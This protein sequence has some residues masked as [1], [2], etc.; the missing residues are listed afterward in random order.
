M[1]KCVLIGLILGAL[2]FQHLFA[3]EVYFS[4][5]GQQVRVQSGD[6]KGVYDLWLRPKADTVKALPKFEIYDAGIGGFADVLAGKPSTTTTFEL[7]PFE[8]LYTVQGNSVREITGTD[9]VKGL[10]ISILAEQKYL[11]RWVEILQLTETAEQGWILRAKTDNGDDVNNFNVRFI[12]QTDKLFDLVSMDLVIGLYKTNP[13]TR[14]QLKPLF[15]KVAPQNL[16]VTGEE[17]TKVSVLDAF[18]DVITPENVFQV[19]RFGLENSWAL[20]LSGSSERLNNMVIQTENGITPWIISPIIKQSETLSAPTLISNAG[21]DCDQFQLRV[22]ANT[23]EYAPEKT[24]WLLENRRFTGIETQHKFTQK[25]SVKLQLITPTKGRYTPLY[26]VTEPTV[27]VNQKPNLVLKG[28]KSIISPSEVL[29]LNAQESS[30]PENSELS[31]A[32]FV[33]GV[34]RGDAPLLNFSA[35]TSGDY[36]VRL[37]LDDKT[38]GSACSTV[39]STFTIRINTQPYGEI[40]LNPIV[41]LGTQTRFTAASLLDSDGDSLAFSWEVNGIQGSNT[42]ES[43]LVNHAERGTFDVKLTVNDISGTTNASFETI[44]SFKVNGAPEPAFTL[45]NLIA[46]DQ[47]LNLNAAPSTDPDQDRLS[48]AWAISDGRTSQNPQFALAFE[49]PGDYEITLTVNDKQGVSNSIKSIKK[50]IRVNEEP[51]PVITSVD[52][53]N[54]ALVVFRADQS[55]DSDQSIAVYSWNF[56]DNSTAQGSQVN[57][58]YSRAGTYTVTLTVDD[59]QNMANSVQ[60]IQKEVIVNKNPIAQFSVKTLVAPN[61]R[62]VLDGSESKDEDGNVTQYLWFHQ[63]KQIGSG[64]QFTYSIAEPG[65][66]VIQLQVKDDSGFDSAIHKKTR[67]IRVNFPP[68]IEWTATPTVTEPGKKTIFSA[69]NSFDFDDKNLNFTWDFG[70]GKTYTGAQISHTFS[71]SGTFSFKITAD[72]NNGLT[73]SKTVYEE[74]IRVNASPIIVTEQRIVTNSKAVVLNAAKSYDADGSPLEFTWILPDGTKQSEPQLTWN[75]PAGGYYKIGLTLNDRDGLQ[76][77]TISTGIDVLVNRPVVALVDSLIESCTGQIIIFSSARSYD[78]DGDQFSTQWDFGDGNTSRDNNPYHTYEKPGVYTATLTLH[79]GISAEPT[80]AKIPVKVSGSPTAR[81]NFV[82][83][84]IC[85]NTPMIFDGSKS[86]DPNG[87]IGAYSWDFGDESVGFGTQVTH[88]FNRA[89]TYTVQLTVIGS[90]A[91]NCSN[92]SVTTATVRVVEGPEARFEVPEWTNPGEVITLDASKSVLNGT[93][94]GAQWIVTNP[95]S[96]ET[97]L[98]GLQQRF[99]PQSSGKLTIQLI[100]EVESGSDC[101]ISYAKKE[102]RVNFPPVLAWDKKPIYA[103]NKA[104]RVRATGSGDR[105]G[106]IQTYTWTLNGNKIEGGLEVQLGFLKPGNYTL[107]LTIS[108]NSG[109]TSGT[110]SKTE[111]FTVNAP[112][113]SQFNL[114]NVIYKGESIQLVPSEINDAEGQKLTTTWMVNGSKMDTTAFVATANAYQIKL[115]QNDE[116][117]LENAV[118]SVSKMVHIVQPPN[119]LYYAPRNV[120]Q[121]YTI[122]AATYHA[123][124]KV[125]LS[126]DGNQQKSWTAT[127]VGSFNL[128]WVWTP[129]DTVLAQTSFPVEVFEPLALVDDKPEAVIVKWN[130]AN[131]FA[132]LTLPALNRPNPDALDSEWFGTTGSLGYGTSLIVP[133]KK[134]E[135]QFT[136]VVKEFDVEG[137]KPLRFTVTVVAE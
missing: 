77:S 125:F 35:S 76:N 73:N 69:G 39:D 110:V 136:V 106:F 18:G 29:E 50:T 22:N 48:Y 51:V 102:M 70:D 2:S 17:D 26:K 75:A 67:K 83:T 132:S 111:T 9:S 34:Y 92:T 95:D 90:D 46:P 134:G 3:Q 32:W 4:I 38:P 94:K 97:K 6:K 128:S 107:G 113:I 15:D 130:P 19:Q 64:E 116:S 33:D 58:Q 60:S 37:I 40:E 93:L 72:D 61:E 23:Y 79:D 129:R 104:V 137:S 56:G 31:F 121:G 59:G 80:I 13:N 122:S 123:P 85:V 57:H 1:K 120:I 66:H 54:D 98:Q 25:G 5:S 84:T 28:F 81:I 55:S 112:P 91:G 43:I 68:E 101:N 49:K 124:E 96:F 24:I 119:M 14:I 133:V 82:D 135:N 20:E 27:F 71:Q 108:D 12:N 115:I 44:R 52:K 7:I 30:D 118:D 42:S 126:I 63:G 45:P 89:G 65:E 11:N 16:V 127:Q 74:T 36:R 78:P 100:V 105:D 21:K 103:H 53:T 131:P 99:T 117:G 86:T 114:P 10:S 62:F 8:K 88:L 109:V 47:I 41:A 87:P